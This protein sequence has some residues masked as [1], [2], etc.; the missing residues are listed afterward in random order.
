MIPLFSILLELFNVEEDAFAR[1]FLSCLNCRFQKIIWDINRLVKTVCGLCRNFRV[2]FPHVVEAI[3]SSKENSW[4]D[5]LTD[6]IAGT[7]ILIYPYF[8]SAH[9]TEG[10]VWLAAVTVFIFLPYR[11]FGM[12]S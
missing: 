2:C 4:C 7:E 6:T 3:F 11:R 8:Y 12:T 9:R 1:A 5:L 10:Y